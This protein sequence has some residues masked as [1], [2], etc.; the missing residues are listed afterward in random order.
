MTFSKLRLDKS[1]NFNEVQ[2]INKLE[3]VSTFSV[4][5]FDKS[6]DSISVQ[7]SNIPCIMVNSFVSVFG[8]IKVFKEVQP[9]RKPANVVSFVASKCDKSTETKYLVL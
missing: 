2:P 4:L 9:E 1:I 8:L 5:R 7:S 6:I 3:A